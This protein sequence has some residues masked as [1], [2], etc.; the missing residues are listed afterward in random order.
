MAT[1]SG[2]ARLKKTFQV[3]Y[4]YLKY[5]K[6]C[7]LS[8]S[9]DYDEWGD[10]SV[11]FT[12]WWESVGLGL[13]GGE[14]VTVATAEHLQSEAHYV[15]AVP[16]HLSPRQ[17]RVQC[18]A[19]VKKLHNGIAPQA[20]Q[21]RWSID[22]TVPIKLEFFRAYLRAMKSRD[23]LIR[24]GQSGS[25]VEI[26]ADLRGTYLEKFERY[27][28]SAE[29]LPQRLMHGDGGRQ[30]DPSLI[31]VGDQTQLNHAGPSVT[32]INDYLRKGE[33]TLQRVAM[34]KFP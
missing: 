2:N 16:R 8:V 15:F 12:R 6:K 26:L 28:E 27:G 31:V 21:L 5:A 24:R 7:S 3:W 4:E 34:G 1:A 20:P 19:L 25:A 14:L 18:E 17:A 29:L 32:A 23:K 10:T 33:D 11:S 22:P 9:S 13:A 30:T